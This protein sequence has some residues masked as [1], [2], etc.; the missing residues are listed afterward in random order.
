MPEIDLDTPEGFEKAACGVVR[1]AVENGFGILGGPSRNTLVALDGEQLMQTLVVREDLLDGH[2]I[3]RA[4]PHQ[5]QALARIY[6]VVVI[7]SLDAAANTPTLAQ[8]AARTL[9]YWDREL[10]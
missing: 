9:D 7:Q 1:L 5:V 4:C 8:E 3:A 2:T 10:R 6:K